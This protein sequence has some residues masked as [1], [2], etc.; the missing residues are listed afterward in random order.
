MQGYAWAFAA[1][2]GSTL[3][4]LAMSPRFAL[5]NIAMVYLLAVLG[6]A[7]RFG[8]GPVVASAVTGVAAFNFFFV[9][10]VHTFTVDDPQHLVTFGMM[11]AVG[12]IVSG[13]TGS[14][15]RQAE[16][17]SRLAL[18][19]ET[20]RMRNTLLASIS[21]DLRT[22]LA[23]I[24]GASSSLAER[25]ERMTGDERRELALSIYRQSVEVS[26]LVAK[27]LEMTRLENGAIELQRDWASLGE[28]AGTVLLRLRE[29]LSG[30]MLM[31]EIPADLPLV[32][33]DAAL[34]EQVLANLLENAARH[35]PPRTLIRLRAQAAPGELQVA[36]EDSGPGLAEGDA[37]RLFAKFQRAAGTPRG[38]VGLGLAICR[39]IVELH[40]GRIRA[41]ASPGGGTAFC[42]TLP[43]GVAP[44]PPA[45][46][47]PAG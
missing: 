18:E 15:R 12:L 9:P 23:V 38:G 33:V 1:V 17:R 11:L 40:G 32:R 13:L 3:A 26:E 31:V 8:R 7:L 35:T 46:A 5:V 25:G 29:R 42:F 30:H 6:I 44:M 14:V 21:H 34:I 39:A 43:L 2:A 24:A 27:V 20:E 10:P 41:E 47:A 28:I 16:A 22:P 36:V 19:A 45:E 4:G 37:A